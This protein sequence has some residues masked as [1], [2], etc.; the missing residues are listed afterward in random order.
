[1][2]LIE[3]FSTLKGGPGSGNWGHAGR[4]GAKGGS[5]LRS[6][7]MSITTGPD[8]KVRQASVKGISQVL[9]HGLKTGNEA[10]VGYDKEGKS[11]DGMP[12]GDNNSCSATAVIHPDTHITI[13]N[14]PSSSSFSDGDLIVLMKNPG[15][16]M[17]V[18][19]HDG[20]IYKLTKPDNW[21]DKGYS[22]SVI[23]KSYL[24]VRDRLMPKYQPKVLKGE[25]S[26][27]EA[28]KAHSHDIVTEL[29][30][31]FGLDYQRIPA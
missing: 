7:A 23:E 15:K 4:P 5:A 12:T 30:K 24:K 1:M 2:S 27:F 26:S 19:G 16:H 10:I 22:S 28:W 6:V 3:L 29:A 17:M 11:I 14:H 13:H 20:T 25:I 31:G 18:V 9:K 21:V 8:Y